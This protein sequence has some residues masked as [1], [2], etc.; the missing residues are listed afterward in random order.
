LFEF[1]IHNVRFL[2]AKSNYFKNFIRAKM[3]R[4]NTAVSGHLKNAWT[5]TK[6]FGWNG[7]GNGLGGKRFWD[8]DACC[9]E[10]DQ[11]REQTYNR[12][13]NRDEQESL[14]HERIQISVLI[15][16]GKWHKRRKQA[17]HNEGYHEQKQNIILLAHA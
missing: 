5:T 14:G 10:S 2:Q 1:V 15:N 13:K 11:Q 8:S 7:R 4:A 16:T 3:P 17:Y 12:A 6:L 9:G